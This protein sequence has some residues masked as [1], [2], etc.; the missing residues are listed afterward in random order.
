MTFGNLGITLSGVPLVSRSKF[1]GVYSFLR[2]SHSPS[3]L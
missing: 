3:A 2:G 1:T